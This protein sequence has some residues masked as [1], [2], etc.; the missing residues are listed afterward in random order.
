MQ[1]HVECERYLGRDYKEI[2]R[3]LLCPLQPTAPGAI[4]L[5]LKYDD[6]AVSNLSSFSHSNGTSRSSSLDPL[7]TCSS[8]RTRRS[9]AKDIRAKVVELA[10]ASIL[11]FSTSPL[12]LAPLVPLLLMVI[13]PAPPAVP[14]SED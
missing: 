14:T 4:P 11:F 8:I 2:K 13:L 10:L 7:P 3:T 1:W 5:N 12:Y 9:S 6:G